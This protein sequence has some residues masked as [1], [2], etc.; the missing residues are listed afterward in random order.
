MS[1]IGKIDQ[2]LQPPDSDGR[3][4]PFDIQF[5]AQLPQ[6][7]GFEPLCLEPAQH[8]FEHIEIVRRGRV[9]RAKLYYLRGRRGKSARITEKRTTT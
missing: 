8:A 1:R 9:R 7:W 5:R 6:P 3:R 4:L 2:L